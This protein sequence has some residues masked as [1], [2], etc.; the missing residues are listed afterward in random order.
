MSLDERKLTSKEREKHAWQKWHRQTIG[1]SIGGGLGAVAGSMVKHDAAPGIGAFGGA[2]AGH[3]KSYKLQ[4]KKQQQVQPVK[5][6]EAPKPTQ[7]VSNG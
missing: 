4:V 3:R 7:A 6:V 1:A 2:V 5:P